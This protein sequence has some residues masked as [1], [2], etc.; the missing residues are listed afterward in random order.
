MTRTA[1]A[2]V[3]RS[4]PRSPATDRPR[5]RVSLRAVSAS[6]GLALHPCLF[7]A[8]QI[9]IAGFSKVFC[10]ESDAGKR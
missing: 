7:P 3:E 8:G 5:C 9:R 4:A 2:A 10:R 1:P 6:D